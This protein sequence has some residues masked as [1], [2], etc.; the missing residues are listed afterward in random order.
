MPI[1]NWT[2]RAITRAELAIF[3]LLEKKIEISSVL[4]KKRALYRIANPAQ[5]DDIF[6][7]FFPFKP[8]KTLCNAILSVSRCKILKLVLTYCVSDACAAVATTN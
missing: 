2:V 1:S 6:L 8:Y 5:N 4:I 3:L 7:I